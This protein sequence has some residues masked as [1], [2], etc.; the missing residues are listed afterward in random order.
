MVDQGHGRRVLTRQQQSQPRVTAP[1]SPVGSGEPTGPITAPVAAIR[2]S[3]PVTAPVAVIPPMLARRQ[4]TDGW[5]RRM[6]WI[7]GA[8]VL[9]GVIALVA[10]QNGLL[11]ATHAPGSASGT[12]GAGA[13]PGAS[14]GPSG[15]A[16]PSTSTVTPTPAPA[17]RAAGTPAPAPAAPATPVTTIGA[18]VVGDATPTTTPNTTTSAPTTTTS[19]ST[20]TTSPS[21]T[22]TTAPSGT[23]SG[24]GSGG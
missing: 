22:T 20:T 12:P 3:G 23:S 4:R 5:L 15:A 2:P 17:T 24:A 18:S 7:L 19:S 8:A 6:T 21:T 16:V 10:T 13:G 9:L 14:G 11:A 1:V